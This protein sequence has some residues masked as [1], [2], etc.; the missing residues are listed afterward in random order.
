MTA[1]EFFGRYKYD[2]ETSKIGS[3]RLGTVY[4][5]YDLQ[6]YRFVA[7]KIAEVKDTKDGTI[8]L[9]NEI[10]KVSHLPEHLNIAKYEEVFTFPQATGTF[11]F[12]IMPYFQTGNL[13]TL[14]SHFSLTENEKETLALQILDGLEFLHSQNIVHGNLKPTNV[15]LEINNSDLGSKYTV[16]IADF[17]MIK[18]SDTANSNDE[19]ILYSSP[20]KLKGEA[21][22][23]NTD[24]WSWAVICYK[25][26]TRKNLFSSENTSS[27]IFLIKNILEEDISSKLNDLPEKWRITL[28]NALIKNPAQR[29]KSTSELKAMLLEGTADFEPKVFEEIDTS[30]EIE[31]EVLIEEDDTSTPLPDVAETNIPQQKP[32]ENQATTPTPTAPKPSKRKKLK[33]FLLM[34]ILIPAGF[35]AY[36]NLELF[37]NKLSE[38]KAKALLVKMMDIRTND[39]FEL[40]SEV[41]TDPTEKYFS[42]SD[43]SRKN[44]IADMEK[45][46]KSWNFEDVKIIDF[47]RTVENMFHFTMTYN[48]RDKK[49]QQITTYRVNGEVGFMKENEQFKINYITNRGVSNSRNSFNYGIIPFNKQQDFYDYYLR[50]NA[51]L[52]Y[53]PDIKDDFLLNYIYGD[54]LSVQPAGFQKDQLKK[55]LQDD[56]I[57]FINLAEKQMSMTWTDTALN[58]SRQFEMTTA[59]VDADF[60]SV[61]V[62][63]SYILGNTAKGFSVQYKNIDYADGKILVLNDLLYVNAVPWS[64]LIH[65]AFLS[66]AVTAGRRVISEEDIGLYPA[67]PNNFYFDTK[68]IFLVYGAEEVPD[69]AYIGPITVSIPLEDMKN[70]L[71]SY[72]KAKIFNSNKVNVKKL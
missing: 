1:E 32:A 64:E 29:I 6:E 56:Y 26:F 46:N 2:I 66:K 35:Y 62:V 23:P 39:Q 3:G 14:I 22:T 71:T 57:E 8:S 55:A 42:E 28:H 69:A 19:D 40:V 10:R 47:G 9:A 30:D 58:Y 31:Y 53:F 25:I 17:G 21:L 12:A 45:F 51:S 5:A 7:L 54:L 52:L 38:K 44:I 49:S 63:E 50:Y 13:Q 67:A 60:L 59:F 24:L 4:K 20:E 65:K 72:F 27:E 11:D 68:R 16:K 15:L 36:N 34:L 70:Y 41:F 61:Q 48:L 43:I 37:G 18:T 33:W